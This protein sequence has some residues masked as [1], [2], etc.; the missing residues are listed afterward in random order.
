MEHHEYENRILKPVEV[1]L[2]PQD[3]IDKHNLEQ[4][5]K[6]RVS[7]SLKGRGPKFLCPKCTEPV[8]HLFLKTPEGHYRTLPSPM[9]YCPKCDRLI[10]YKPEMLPI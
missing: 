8:K 1:K 2:T 4:R 5:Q 9:F 6:L 3:I 7:N 10:R